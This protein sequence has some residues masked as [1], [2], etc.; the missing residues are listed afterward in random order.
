[1]LQ[2]GQKL[3]TGQMLQ[4]GRAR[5]GTWVGHSGAGRLV[6]AAVLLAVA[7]ILVLDGPPV[8][9]APAGAPAG[10]RATVVMLLP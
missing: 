7:A 10:P 5:Y 8:A 4:T 2:S 6:L 9:R 3:Q 1:V